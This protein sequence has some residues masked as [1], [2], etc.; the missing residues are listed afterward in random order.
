MRT[1]SVELLTSTRVVAGSTDVR[2]AIAGQGTDDARVLG[3]SAAADVRERGAEPLG[4]DALAAQ[5]LAD[6][7]LDMRQPDQQVQDHAGDA[8]RKQHDVPYAA[9]RSYATW[10]PTMVARTWPAIS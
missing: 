4:G 9:L 10:P 1:G 5:H 2:V 8:Q 6:R 7:R 3:A